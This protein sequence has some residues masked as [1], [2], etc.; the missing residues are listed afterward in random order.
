MK[1]LNSSGALVALAVAG[2]TCASP[3]SLKADLVIDSFDAT[4]GTWT[5]TWGT[6][7]VL[8]FDADDAKGSAASGSLK[9]TAEYF[10]PD[11]GNGWEQMVITRNF[12]APVIGSQYE[13]I[14]I[15]VKVDE[16]S[17]AN[18]DGHYGYFELKRTSDGTAMG[19]VNITSKEWTTISFPIAPTEGT[20]AGILIQNGSSTFQG[21]VSFKID[22]LRFVAPPAPLTTIDTFD[23][24][25]TAA[26]WT[27]TWGSSPVITWD[28]QDAKGSPDSGSLKV[29]AEYF[30]PDGG[31]GWE[32]M[33]ITRSFPEPVVGTDHVSVSVDVKVGEDSVANS[34]G[35]YGYFELK[36]SSD[37][38]PLGGVNLTSKSWTTITFSIPATEGTLSAILIQNGSSTFQGPIT[39]YL[40]NFVFTQKTGGVQP[41][42]LAIAKNTQPG[43]KLIA[44]APGQAYQRQNVIYVPSEQ[45]DQNLWW[46]NQGEA[47]SYSV[48]WG[49]FPDRATQAGFQGHIIL[50]KDS[51]K[52][53]TPDW[54]DANVILVEFQYAGNPAENGRTM[55]RARFLHKVNEPAG[56]AMLYRTPDRA[57][58]GP[59]GV[60]G[61]VW[62]E[63][64]LGTWTITFKNDTDITITSADNKTVDI[65]IPTEEVAAFEPSSAGI[66][67]L[68]GVQ[69]NSDAR[70]G[71][72]ALITRITIVK[73]ASTIVDDNFQGSELAPESWAARAQDAGGVFPLSPDIGFLVS[74]NL[75][76]TGFVLNAAPSLAGP[77]SATGD[78]RQVGA[79]RVLLLDKA[80]VPG[81]KAGYFRLVEAPPAQ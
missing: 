70:V 23:T 61:E 5:A 32:Q 49:D 37:G 28:P 33:V 42:T 45:L 55:A 12:D 54:N 14:A 11:G 6:A 77:W 58:E 16:S 29:T 63:S 80:A 7:P 71:Q 67:A 2:F 24:E 17:V 78:P 25:E 60:L 59:V 9:V 3:S 75:P 65:T 26:G 10:T 40:D 73:G 53:S 1:F 41:P 22:N 20:L 64:M 30:T 74:W 8:T 4:A 39:Y 69:P 52:S 27:A 72:S 36:R 79:R 50:S 51:G 56:N 35:N 62:A 47:L 34:D 76:D 15:D 19:G 46:V 31:N 44:S 57:A 68:F 13:A 81:D 66:S 43:L 38:T 48:T 18:T 21:P